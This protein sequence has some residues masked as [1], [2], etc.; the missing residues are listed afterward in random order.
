MGSNEENPDLCILGLCIDRYM[1]NNEVQLNIACN[2]FFK[3]L[4]TFSK[5]VAT[6]SKHILITVKVIQQTP[7]PL[8]IFPTMR[9][10]VFVK[11]VTI[12]SPYK[13]FVPYP[14]QLSFHSRHLQTPT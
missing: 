13:T 11:F 8:K 10:Q 5:L 1:L 2:D 3:N 4:K 12:H 9:N 7:V 6:T 14:P